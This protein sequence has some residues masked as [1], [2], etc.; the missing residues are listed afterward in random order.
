M[1]FSKRIDKE[2]IICFNQSYVYYISHGKIYKARKHIGSR[3]KACCRESTRP[4][5][6][7]VSTI[8][9]IDSVSVNTQAEIKEIL[10]GYGIEERKASWRKYYKKA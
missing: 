7:K 9:R 10:K 8:K 2:N 5:N 4:L 1:S 6:I 3:K